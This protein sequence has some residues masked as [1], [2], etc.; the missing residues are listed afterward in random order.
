MI[1]LS[2]MIQDRRVLALLRRGLIRKIVAKRL[3]LTI[4]QVRHAERRLRERRK[5]LR[6]GSEDRRTA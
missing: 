5:A 2:T 6:L 3:R 4:D 1:K